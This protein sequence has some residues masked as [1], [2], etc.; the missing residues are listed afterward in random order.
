M[1]LDEKVATN[2]VEFGVRHANRMNEVL[3]EADDLR[4]MNDKQITVTALCFA[5]AM[6]QLTQLPI[7]DFIG[8]CLFAYKSVNV[9][10]KAEGEVVEEEE[11]EA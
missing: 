8:L 2:L 3:L 6:A 5:S 4:A 11:D 7:E 9:V 10:H 1:M